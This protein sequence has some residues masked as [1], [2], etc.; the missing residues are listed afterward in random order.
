YRDIAALLGPSFGGLPVLEST[1]RIR[2]ADVVAL[3]QAGARFYA[4]VVFARPAWARSHLRGA[5]P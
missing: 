5:Q 3:T 4:E 1:G 2:S